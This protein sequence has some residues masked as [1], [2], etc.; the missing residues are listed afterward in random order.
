MTA[1]P[2]VIVGIGADGWDGLSES[3]KGAILGAEVLMGSPRQL[4]LVPATHLGA[5]RAPTR[6]TWPSPM[7]PALPSMFA[8]NADRRVCVL[9]SGDPMF[10]GLGVTLVRLLG[11]DNVQVISH[12]SSVALASARMGWASAEIDVVSLV[13]RDSAT[14][15]ASVTD[16]A[17]LLVLSN[18]RSTPGEVARLL[19]GA[20]FGRSI[21]TVLAQLGGAG[22][23]RTVTVADEWDHADE[24]VDAL[25]VLAV[26]CIAA[27]PLLRLTRIRGY[28]MLLLSA[29]VR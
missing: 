4:D 23:S 1:H 11:A 13:N 19:S 28:R 17:R 24:D 16:G 7:I 18:G 29:T 8:E 14:V 3:A 21:V 27:D 5:R 9:A 2:V 12:P 26:E 15:L 25:N 20:G 6:L 22:E 10:H